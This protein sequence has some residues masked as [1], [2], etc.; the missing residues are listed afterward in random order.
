MSTTT[1]TQDMT[2]VQTGLSRLTSY[3]SNQPTLRAVLTS[4]LNRLQDVE[5]ALWQVIEARILANATGL[6]L[7]YIGGVIGQPR[8]VLADDEYRVAIKLRIQANHSNGTAEDVI[9]M[10][11]GLI[12]FYALQATVNYVELFPVAFTTVLRNV[13]GPY[14]AAQLLGA[15]KASGSRGILQYTTWPPGGDLVWS[16]RYL[17]TPGERGWATTYDGRTSGGKIA[18]AVETVR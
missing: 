8:G 1:P 18:G 9:G 7:D 10:C 3:L 5:N 11:A 14:T 6:M 2:Y 15:A 13:P 12:G 4:Y 16:S 17:P